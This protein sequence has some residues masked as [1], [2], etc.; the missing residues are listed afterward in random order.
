[1]IWTSKPTSDGG[2]CNLRGVL[3]ITPPKWAQ[4]VS[5]HMAFE[6]PARY[7][8]NIGDSLTNNAWGKKKQH[9]LSVIHVND[10][11]FY[12]PE[13]RIFNLHILRPCASSIFTL[14]SFLRHMF[15]YNIPPPQ[16]RRSSIFRIPPT[17][18]FRILIHRPTSCSAF[19]FTLPYHLCLASYIFSPMFGTSVFPYFVIPEFLNHLYS[20]HP[21]KYFL[22]SFAQPVSVPRS[23]FH[24]LGQV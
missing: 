16:F 8:F 17:S 12:N 4:S 3:K 5:Y 6:R 20:H 7:S 1:M 24:T 23:H 10:F 22:A 15:S 11:P 19:L 21:S 18:I 13:L 9:S 2:R 14:Y